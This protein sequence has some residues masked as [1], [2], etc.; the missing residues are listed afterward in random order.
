MFMLPL[1]AL[2]RRIAEPISFLSPFFPPMWKRK[3]WIFR[4]SA[5]T[6]KVPLPPLPL[7]A[8]A[9][10][11]TSLVLKHAFVFCLDSFYK[12]VFRHILN[13]YHNAYRYIVRTAAGG[14]IIHYHFDSEYI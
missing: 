4:T 3:R 14:I 11:S 5:F 8:S 7:P 12:A 2:L 10:A 9:S 6:N 13:W 1:F